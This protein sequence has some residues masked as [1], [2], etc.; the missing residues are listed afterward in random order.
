MRLFLFV[1]VFSAL[2]SLTQF[3]RAA[4]LTR[5]GEDHHPGRRSKPRVRKCCFSYICGAFALTVYLV[6]KIVSV[7]C[8][9]DE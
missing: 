4:A 5:S 8:F 6:V 7:K 1:S 3:S 9:E 2:R